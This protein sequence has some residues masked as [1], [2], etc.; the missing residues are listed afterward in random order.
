MT[1]YLTDYITLATKMTMGLPITLSIYS[2]VHNAKYPYGKTF[3]RVTVH[4][5]PSGNISELHDIKEIHS[6]V[7]KDVLN[8]PEVYGRL[9]RYQFG[10]EIYWR[11]RSSYPDLVDDT[12]NVICCKNGTFIRA[13]TGE[14]YIKGYHNPTEFECTSCPPGFVPGGKGKRGYNVQCV[15]DPCYPGKSV[16]TTSLH[17]TLGYHS[18]LNTMTCM[19]PKG[20]VSCPGPA[21]SEL[22]NSYICPRSTDRPIC[23]EDPCD[24]YTLSYKKT[25]QLQA[26]AYYDHAKGN[27][28]PNEGHIDLSKWIIGFYEGGPKRGVLSHFNLCSTVFNGYAGL[29]QVLRPTRTPEVPSQ[30]WLKNE[31]SHISSKIDN[32]THTGRKLYLNALTRRGQEYAL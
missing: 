2:A 7:K 25:V 31:V 21:F 19:C 10:D 26:M 11:C 16:M 1:T 29:A 13:K 18:T 9:V 8:C 30:A 24:P 20:Y 12:G 6:P 4:E 5:L 17:I 15:R 32:D 28:V 27:C 22:D 23:V 14:A 3:D